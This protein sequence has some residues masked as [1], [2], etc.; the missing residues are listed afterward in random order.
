MISSGTQQ[1]TFSYGPGLQRWQSVTSDDGTPVRRVLYGNNYERVV[2]AADSVREFFYLGHDIIAV[3]LNGGPIEFYM[4]QTDHLGSLITVRDSLWASKFHCT[5]DA[6][7]KPSVTKNTIGMIRGY[8]GHEM[9]P[10]YG[11]INTNGRLYDPQ[12]GRFLSP[13]NY[14]QL[15]DLSQSFNRYSYCLNNPLKYTDPDGEWIH[16]LIGAGIGGLINLGSKALSGQIH[17]IGDGFAAFGIGAVAGGIGALTGGVGFVSAGGAVGGAGGFFAGAVSGAVGASFSMPI[18]S[19]G[20]SLYFGDPMMTSKEYLWGIASSALLGGTIN[21]AVALKNGRSFWSGKPNIQLNIQK[22]EPVPIIDSD[23]KVA[24]F[25]SETTGLNGKLT[26]YE[27]GQIGVNRAIEEFEANGGTFLK[28]E[29]TVEVDGVR[30]RFDFAGTKNGELYLFEVKNGPY[31]RPTPNQLR[32]I[33]KLFEHS[34]SF[35]PIGRIAA[36]IPVLRAFETNRVP[37][38]GN[39]HIIYIHY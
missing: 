17:S 13:D 37:F 33:P 34:S 23:K 31:S 2:Y 29:V 4:A 21:G 14:V 24:T 11:L 9:L 8:T 28:K 1:T 6:W 30:N 36:D 20:N 32:N 18:L 5:Y 39:Y 7:G 25:K 26:P 3:R 19:V 12:I 16:I 22:I 38:S 10:E 35:T 27:K 15:P